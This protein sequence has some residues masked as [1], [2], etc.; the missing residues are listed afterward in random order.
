MREGEG[1]WET[2]DERRHDE[3]G[4]KER[5]GENIMTV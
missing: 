4:I 2:E 5:R 1:G 3:E